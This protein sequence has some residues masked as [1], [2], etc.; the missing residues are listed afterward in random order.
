MSVVLKPTTDN[1]NTLSIVIIG[2]FFFIFGFVTWLN[3]VLIPYLQIACQLNDF[4]SYLVAFAF[5]ISYFVMA[6]P[7]SWVLEKTGLKNG[8]T[9]GLLVMAAGALIFIP[10]AHYRAY[11][12]FLLGLFVLGTGLAL[13]QTASNPYVTIL[14]PIERAAQRIS[15]MGICNKVAGV[16]SP[17]ILGAIILKDTDQ[18][19]V[20]LKSMD[21]L[22]KAAELDVL[23]QRVVAPYLVITAVLLA[24]AGLV[25]FANLPEI[26]AEKVNAGAEGA[27]E[28]FSIWAFPSLVLGVVALFFAVGCEVMAGDTI[29]KYGQ[30]IGISLASAKVFTS[31]TLFAMVISY[32]FGIIAIPR[33]IRQDKA[34]AYSAIAGLALT[35]AAIFTQGYMSVM[36]IAALGLANALLWP[37]IW[38]LAIAGLGKFTKLGASLLVMSI[39]G[40]AFLP[41]LYGKLVGSFGSQQSYWLLAP[42]YAFIL[43]YALAGSK[44][45]Q[46]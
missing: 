21:D 38:P 2:I 36:F 22:A 32:I 41:L 45:V 7:S 40:G 31:Y 46:W 14:G 26:E 33:F 11:G 12:I 5:Y 20:R 44:K 16:I 1:N 39:A 6:V 34:L 37:A 43:Y 19:V 3:G 9:V 17:L 18:L 28:R 42:C 35:C 8:M 25:R 29:I 23:A 24:L 30:S 13:L 15:I 27:A 10:A 4:Q